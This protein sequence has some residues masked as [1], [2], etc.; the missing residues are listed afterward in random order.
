MCDLARLSCN[1][2]TSDDELHSGTCQKKSW[3]AG[4]VSPDARFYSFS[5]HR[6]ANQWRLVLKCRD[7]FS[8]TGLGHQQD[9][10]MTLQSYDA[11]KNETMHEENLIAFLPCLAVSP[12]HRA[13]NFCTPLIRRR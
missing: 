4:V 2:I 7:V 13:K 3:R 10:S 5:R 12:H 9:A 11:A 8:P 6:P 1:A